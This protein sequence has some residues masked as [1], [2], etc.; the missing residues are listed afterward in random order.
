M[1]VR[2][3]SA[4]MLST[5]LSVFLHARSCCLT[6][7]LTDSLP[8][9][10]SPFTLTTVFLSLF[11]LSFSVF[12]FSFRSPFTCLGVPHT[13][14][15]CLCLSLSLSVCVCVLYAC[16]NL[17]S[18]LRVFHRGPSS[19]L[20]F[21]LSLLFLTLAF[22]YRAAICSPFL[23]LPFS[24][25]ASLSP[26]FYSLICECV[27]ASNP[28]SL[29]SPSSDCVFVLFFAFWTWM[30]NEAHCLFLHVCMY[31]CVSFSFC[32]CFSFACARGALFD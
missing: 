30:L 12:F 6:R 32:C 19:L 31:V 11:R 5:P 8:F 18:F 13:P 26:S 28:S 15:L 27:R 10:C 17:F 14:P 21:P 20:F 23:P 29:L 4:S 25:S 7:S 22:V 9:V 16:V 3:L 1:C 24:W 2:V